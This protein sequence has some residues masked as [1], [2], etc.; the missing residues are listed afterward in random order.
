MTTKLKDITKSI[1]K[2]FKDMSKIF[3][4]IDMNDVEFSNNSKISNKNGHLV[5]KGKFKSITINGKKIK[6]MKDF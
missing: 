5:I 3:D 2:I 1:N 6:N 4:S